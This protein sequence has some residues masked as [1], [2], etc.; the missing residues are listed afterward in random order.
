[1]ECPYLEPGQAA[2]FCSASVSLMIPSIEESM[3]YCTTEE[4]YR[5]PML[6]SH[7]LRGGEPRCANL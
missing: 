4:H 1:M 5:C 3:S 2:R 6:V 7:I